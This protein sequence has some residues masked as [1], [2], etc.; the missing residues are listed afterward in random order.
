MADATLGPF[1][2]LLKL[3]LPS[4]L[5]FTSLSL[6]SSLPAPFCCCCCS[7]LL[8][9]AS[10]NPSPET[11]FSQMHT[12]VSLT[13]S[14]LPALTPTEASP[15]QDR[16]V[17]PSYHPSHSPLPSLLARELP[18]PSPPPL[19]SSCK[20]TASRDHLS[21]HTVHA[22]CSNL[23]INLR[24]LLRADANLLLS[25]PEYESQKLGYLAPTF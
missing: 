15:L 14:P 20:L 13:S 22:Q 19:S 12:S 5:L 7:S 3:Q 23:G 24:S 11:L 2:L 25:S 1:F 16:T 9:P 6:F 18:R 17:V 8:S 21:V 10:Y 4:P